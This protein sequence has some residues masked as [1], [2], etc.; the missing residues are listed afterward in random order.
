MKKLYVSKIKSVLGFDI[1]Y[2]DGNYIRK[3]INEEF[4]N[5]GEHFRFK[6]IPKK[7]F[8]IDKE[9][10]PSEV[11][12]YV[13]HM[14]V[15]YHLMEKGL[16]Y[17]MAIDKA[18]LVEEKERKKSKY[19]LKAKKKRGNFVDMIHKKLLKKYSEGNL[20]VWVVDGELVR[21]K[22]FIDFTE[23]G[24]DKVYSF[25]PANEIWIDNDLSFRERKFVLLHEVH[26]RNLMAEGMN[27]S[28]AHHSSSIIEH[29]C[30]RHPRKTKNY[31]KK[32]FE[33]Y[34]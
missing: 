16:S 19:F 32:E 24:H 8:W 7:E 4:T 18:D 30:R 33:K 2:V 28:H 27:Y 10:S 3:N 29:F 20:K 12:F 9:Y 21:D 14:I 34:K 13:S 31:L 1:F 17:S 23:G 5:F 11:D 22:Y 15:E 26:E 25:I 6:F